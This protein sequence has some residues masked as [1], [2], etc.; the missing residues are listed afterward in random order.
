MIY[1]VSTGAGGFPA[2]QCS[3]ESEQKKLWFPITACFF[4]AKTTNKGDWI[5]TTWG[6]TN[7]IFDPSSKMVDLPSNSKDCNG[8][9]FW[10]LYWCSCLLLSWLQY[11]DYLDVYPRYI[12]TVSQ[13]LVRHLQYD[14]VQYHIHHSRYIHAHL[15][16]FLCIRV[17]YLHIHPAASEIVR[18]GVQCDLQK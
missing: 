7:K 14:D 8:L 10:S 5:S 16:T 3:E 11:L 2:I 12:V 13:S 4:E 18:V 9:F 15:A 6:L 17:Q 1:G